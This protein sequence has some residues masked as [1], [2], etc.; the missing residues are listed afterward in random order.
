MIM[1]NLINF[2]K[3]DCVL[4][5]SSLGCRYALQTQS[6]VHAALKLV[7]QLRDRKVFKDV[8]SVWFYC[9]QHSGIQIGKECPE[10]KK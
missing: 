4:R 3:S 6:S 1:S 9:F 8:E 5:S 2:A 7:S 10:V